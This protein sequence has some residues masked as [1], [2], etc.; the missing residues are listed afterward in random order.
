MDKKGVKLASTG[1]VLAFIQS[2]VAQVGDDTFGGVGLSEGSI[3]Q[4]Y[5]DLIGIQ[6]QDPTQFI[7]VTSSIGVFWI[8]T[9]IIMKVGVQRFDSLEEAVM[10]SSTRGGSE[11]RNLVAVLSGLFVLSAIGFNSFGNIINSWMGITM[12]FYATGVLAA[13]VFWLVGLGRYGGVGLNRLNA[14]A[15]ASEAKT[16]EMEADAKEKLK[17]AKQRLGEIGAEEEEAGETGN[18]EEAR[19]AAQKLEAVLQEM[20]AALEEIEMIDEKDESE[21]RDIVNAA[22]SADMGAGL[23]PEK[24][25]ENRLDAIKNALAII[26]GNAGTGATS[27]AIETTINGSLPFADYSDMQDSVQ[28][29]ISDLEAIAEQE[30]KDEGTLTA[31]MKELIDIVQD[32]ETVNELLQGLSSE[33]QEA[34]KAANFEEELARQFG[35]EELY[36]EGEVEERQVR[37]LGE[38]LE[39]LEE[40]H[41][42]LETEIEEAMQLVNKQFGLEESELEELERVRENIIPDLR[43]Y[44]RG[45]VQNVR[46]SGAIDP[47][48]G[49]KDEQLVD[50]LDMIDPDSI[51]N[52]IVRIERRMQGADGSLRNRFNNLL[53]NFP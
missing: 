13:T 4:I 11:G 49:G 3:L 14:S 6:I 17:D 39:E 26:E 23:G 7:A 37:Q 42:N 24:D 47:T 46:D 51:E 31:E 27:G 28:A 40:F 50:I 18:D 8:S 1:L 25:F 43:G 2:V 33:I 36:E 16:K 41:Q 32:F 48:T 20:N 53:N 22:K 12:A 52:M 19:D 35:D 10:P 38:K 15:T 44:Y 34:R 45:A 29:V 30:S 21:I 5:S 9:Y